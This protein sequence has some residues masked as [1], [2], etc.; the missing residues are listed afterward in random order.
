MKVT[1]SQL[2]ALIKEELNAKDQSRKDSLD[3][4]KDKSDKEKD[5]LK[6][7]EHQ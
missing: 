2:K 4:K 1:L 3:D 5:E 6:D 7:L